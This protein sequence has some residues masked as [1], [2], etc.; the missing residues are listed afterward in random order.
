M[1][2]NEGGNGYFLSFSYTDEFEFNLKK[3][4]NGKTT[5]TKV[6]DEITL[7]PEEI[8]EAFENHQLK[9]NAELEN[10]DHFLEVNEP[11]K[12]EKEVKIRSELKNE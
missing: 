12:V 6:I 11:K 4:G 10:D 3:Y 7:T 2:R 5:K 1:I 9:A 8:E